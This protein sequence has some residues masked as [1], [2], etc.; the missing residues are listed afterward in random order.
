MN[1][2]ARRDWSNY[3]N[4]PKWSIISLIH[5]GAWR[6]PWIVAFEYGGVSGAWEAITERAV[7]ER[8]VPRLGE[9]V[10]GIVK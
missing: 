7:L 10:E 5:A 4:A 6:E 9:M 3:C 2:G 1:C 8:D